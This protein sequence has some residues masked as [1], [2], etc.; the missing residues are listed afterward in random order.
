MPQDMSKKQQLMT[1]LRADNKESAIHLLDPRAERMM[2]FETGEGQLDFKK[3][4]KDLEKL[5]K[6]NPAG[7]VGP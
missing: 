4:V 7:K 6:W 3:M 1:W 5:L 2:R